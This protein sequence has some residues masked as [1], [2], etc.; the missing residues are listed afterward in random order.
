MPTLTVS[1]SYIRELPE[2]KKSRLCALFTLEGA[3]TEIWYE[4]DDIYRDGLCTE[5]SDTFLVALLPYLMKNN[6]DVVLEGKVSER[7]YHQLTAYLI[8]AFD[9]YVRGYSAVSVSAELDAAVL[10]S[11]KAVGT[12]CSGGIDSLYTIACNTGNKATGHNITHLTFFNAGSHGNHGGEQAR[13]FFHERLER[14]RLLAEELGLPLIA[15][16]TNINEFLLLNHLETH[17]FRSLSAVLALQKLFSVYYYS[18][19]YPL[20][21]FSISK[22]YA[23]I[24]YAD[25]F[26]AHCLTTEN[27]CFYI[28]GLSETRMDKTR[29]V[30]GFPPAYRHL[31]VCVALERNCGVCDKCVRTH[32]SLYA[33]DSLQHF[34]DVFDLDMLKAQRNRFMIYLVAQDSLMNRE[35]R[36]IL[37]QNGKP[38]PLRLY[39]PGLLMRCTKSARRRLNDSGW[40]SPVYRKVKSLVW[41]KIPKGK[42][43]K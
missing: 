8:P 29:V 5:R 24:A 34:G 3:S 13:R 32:M 18:S 28:S 43:G 16:D 27:T 12:G 6:I 33:L 31:N 10:P 2:E 19:G 4:V 37:A 9:K 7:L 25:L 1:A 14:M 23:A 26:M 11:G 36:Q 42:V 41:W 15:V 20:S 17:T 40:I 30:A 39:L 35:I 38:I 21:E 22:V